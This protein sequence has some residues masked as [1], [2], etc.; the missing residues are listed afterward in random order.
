MCDFSNY[1]DTVRSIIMCLYHSETSQTNSQC[2]MSVGRLIHLQ[3]YT[4]LLWKY[5]CASILTYPFRVISKY[6]L[7]IEGKMLL[8]FWVP[9]RWCQDLRLNCNQVQD[10][11]TVCMTKF[12]MHAATTTE[13]SSQVHH[14]V[15][16]IH[17]TI[18]TS[19]I[20]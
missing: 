17:G 19:Y 16:K 1:A 9:E 12:S 13:L 14:T 8:I 18:N 4:H 3:F 2:L 5:T 20:L 15:H 10:H 11:C 6:P 7:T